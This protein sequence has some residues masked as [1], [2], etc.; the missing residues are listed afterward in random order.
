MIISPSQADTLIIALWAAVILFSFVLGTSRTTKIMLTVPAAA[1]VANSFGNFFERIFLSSPSF[2]QGLKLVN[3]TGD[4]DTLIL[5]KILTFAIIAVLLT[6]K[7]AFEVSLIK[8][9]K[10]SMST[11]INSLF[12]FLTGG[13]I[14]TVVVVFLSGLAFSPLSPTTSTFTQLY[15]ESPLVKIMFDYQDIWFSAPF[16]ALIIWS[17][18]AS[19]FEE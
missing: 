14:V 4:N 3:L 8:P 7:G 2:V 17:F 6:T 16:V 1:F 11:G 19:G 10:A 12:G 15:N 13:V 9:Q 5:F 18:F